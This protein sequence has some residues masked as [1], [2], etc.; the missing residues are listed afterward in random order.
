MSRQLEISVAAKCDTD[1]RFHRSRMKKR[2]KTD[3]FT[4]FLKQII[5]MKIL[6]FYNF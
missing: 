3:Y 2:T 6:I 1:E 5:F 4:K